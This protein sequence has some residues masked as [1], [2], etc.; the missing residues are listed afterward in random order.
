MASVGELTEVVKKNLEQRGVLNQVK[1]R[2]RAEVYNAIE[3]PA[4][5]RPII[6]NENILIN[7][8][9]REYLEFNKY[10][11]TSSVLTAESGMAKEP[12]DREFLR[13]ELNVVEDAPSR[14]VPLLYSIVAHYTQKGPATNP[15]Q[16]KPRSAFLEHITKDEMGPSGPDEPIVVKGGHR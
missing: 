1:A 3:R 11:Y 4:E 16:Q 9:I 6:T 15:Q 2:I 13:T 8:L 10:Q 7:E 5:G 14:S 12:L